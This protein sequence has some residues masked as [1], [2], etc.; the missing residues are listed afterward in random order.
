MFEESNIFYVLNKPE[1]KKGL[2]KYV[3][4]MNTLCHT[5]VAN[6]KNFQKLYN[7]FYRMRQRKPEFYQI[8]FTYL[9]KIKSCDEQISF[10]DVFYYIQNHT[11][12]CE[13]SFSSK[14][15]ATVYPKQP[16]WDVFVLNNLGIKKIYSKSKN[17]E[18]KIIN[19]YN[20]ICQWYEK[21][22]NSVDGARIISTFD[23]IYPDV[24]ITNTKKIDLFLWQHRVK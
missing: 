15:F 18:Q 24:N 2:Q 12:R 11:G 9:E 3:E 23:K 6:D 7:A 17:R 14:L 4:I 16:V 20:E 13:A 1:L 10:E 21:K 22:L 8:Y 19:A 5:N